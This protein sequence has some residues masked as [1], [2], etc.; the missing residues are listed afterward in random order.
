MRSPSDVKNPSKRLKIGAF[1]FDPTA[2]VLTGAGIRERLEPQS[3]A[4]LTVLAARAGEIVS[5]DALMATVWDNRPV[6]DDAIRVVVKKL[7]VALGDDARNPSYIKT[8]PL[9]GYQLIAPVETPETKVAVR[10]GARRSKV[11]L[12]AFALLVVAALLA[13]LMPGGPSENKDRQNPTVNLLTNLKGSELRADYNPVINTLVYSHRDSSEGLLKLMATNLTSGKTQ[14]LTW[15]EANYANASWLPDGT[16]MAY[17]R[18]TDDGTSHYYADY[19]PANG[20]HAVVQLDA[21]ALE[22]KSLLG[23]S[24]NG[25]AL[26]VK[27]DYQINASR[28]ISLHDLATGTLSSIT[29]PSVTGIGDFYARESSGGGLLAILRARSANI[30]ELLVLDLESGALALNRVI[31]FAADKLVWSEDDGAIILSGFDGEFYRYDMGSDRFTDL[32]IGLD[33]INDVL[34]HCGNGCIFARQHSGNYLDIEERPNPFLPASLLATAHMESSGADDLPIYSESGDALYFVSLAPQG[35]TVNRQAQVSAPEEIAVL[36]MGG[37]IR[38]LQINA[39]QSALTGLV[40]GRVFVLDTTSGQLTYVT[41]G[42][43]QASNPVWQRGGDALFYSLF[44][45]GRHAI[46]AHD[47]TSGA[48]EKIIDDHLALRPLDQGRRLAIDANLNAWLLTPDAP[49]QKIASVESASPNRWQVVGDKFY[50]S[51]REG[52]HSYLHYQSLA[53]D[54]RGKQGI[55]TNQFRLNFDIHPAGRKMLL[56]KSLLAD[57]NIVKVSTIERREP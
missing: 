36:P 56:V 51:R 4:F 30:N 26:Y 33:H 40:G 1:D 37:G 23:W 2:G 8:V 28:G 52:S 55:G 21:N 10:A 12:A 17:T 24:A 34:F 50:Y 20:L 38:S 5:R 43:E 11:A 14:R 53:G 7:R 19:D 22:G 35:L 18:W 48:R 57:S 39:S 9:K 16:G 44:E 42:V 46:Y 32:A 3:A 15:D 49:R 45:K 31:P 29:A 54:D 27:D 6:S 41:S 25:K 13:V 47:L